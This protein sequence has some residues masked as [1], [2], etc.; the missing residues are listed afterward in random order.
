MVTVEGEPRV[1][2]QLSPDHRAPEWPHGTP[3]QIHLDLWVEDFPAAHEHV[4]ALGAR[5]LK[6]ARG[7]TAGDDYQVYADPAG[8][9]FCLCFL[10]GDGSYPGAG[11]NV[12]S[13]ISVRVRR[14][15]AFASRCVGSVFDRLRPPGNIT[16]AFQPHSVCSTQAG[17]IQVDL[18]AR[19]V[20]PH[21]TMNA[22]LMLGRRGGDLVLECNGD[23]IGSGGAPS[24]SAGARLGEVDL[25]EAVEASR[26]TQTRT[27]GMRRYRVRRGS[28]V[29][30]DRQCHPSVS[31]STAESICPTPR[32]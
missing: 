11:M 24:R 23:V 14:S 18:G 31:T 12:P 7:N 15:H 20:F 30:S 9:P 3:Q 29:G 17:E 2:V 21:A 16:R 13:V 5:V 25:V 6:E 32:R 8:H 4:I 10:V 26:A 27:S 19:A 28:R 1:G 22:Q